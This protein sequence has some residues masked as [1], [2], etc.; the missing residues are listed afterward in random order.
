MKTEF[1]VL[2]H[3]FRSSHPTIEAEMGL[4]LGEH[5][6]RPVILIYLRLDMAGE[7]GRSPKTGLSRTTHT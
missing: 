2:Q 3:F 4:V 1:E 6:V 5:C 7:S